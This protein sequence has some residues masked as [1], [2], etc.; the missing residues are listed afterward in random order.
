MK[1][2][3][4]N[5]EQGFHNGAGVPRLAASSYLNTAPLIWSFLH[6]SLA[7]SV[8]L[9][10][11]KAPARSAEL[12]ARRAVDFALVPI[13]EYAR[14]SDIELI[15]GVC[16]GARRR[17]RSVVIATRGCEL[18]DVRSV[19]LDAASRTSATLTEIIFREF[20]NR[21]VRS[22]S[23]RHG[24]PD[25]QEGDEKAIDEFDARLVIGD[26]AMRLDASRWRIYDL[27][28]VWH[29]FTGCGFVFAM[30]MQQKNA[31]AGTA[32]V[33]F[34]AARDEGLA[35]THDI[36]NRYGGDIPLSPD[37]LQAYLHENIS[38]RLDASM[39]EG[40]RLYFRLAHKHNLIPRLPAIEFAD[41]E[42]QADQVFAQ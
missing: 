10:T 20:F 33:D 28:E 21:E 16:V 22:R 9:I 7:N 25:N 19:D 39:R 17:V 34:A 3:E 4:R 12:L 27:A 24:E 42:A 5:G 38:Y 30:W 1:R 26:P 29:D 6:G 2:D 14:I 37:E 40:L 13:I 41:D 35:H 15:P 32:Q 36:I 31:E 11:D 18:A 8:E 23:R